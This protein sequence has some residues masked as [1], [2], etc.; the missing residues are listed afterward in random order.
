MD[1]WNVPSFR[2]LRGPSGLLPLE[3]AYLAGKTACSEGAISHSTAAKTKK[4]M[5]FLSI[6]PRLRIENRG[7]LLI[8][9]PSLARELP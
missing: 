3:V 7:G 9:T 2:N 8:P 6:A 4:A 1:I 5:I